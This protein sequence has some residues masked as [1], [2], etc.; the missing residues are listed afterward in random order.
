MWVIDLLSAA[1][2]YEEARESEL[3]WPWEIVLA[4]SVVKTFVSSVAAAITAS[5]VTQ[6]VGQGVG[7]WTLS[8]A[9]R[10]TVGVVAVEDVV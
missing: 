4:L 9:S 3:G 7:G 10:S 1:L 6:L 5:G 8:A 2:A